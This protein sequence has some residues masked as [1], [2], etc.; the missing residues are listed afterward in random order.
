VAHL[1]T[2][3]VVVALHRIGLGLLLVTV[4]SVVAALGF[5][6]D[7]DSLMTAVTVAGLTFALPG[8]A[9][10]GLA[11]WFDGQAAALEGHPRGRR[12]IPKDSPA[13]HPFRAPLTG[14]LLAIAATGGGW[15]V[16]A[17][18]DPLLPGSVPFITFFAAVAISGWFGG[19][20]PAVLSTMLSAVIA[21]YFYMEPAYAFLL[22]DPTQAMRLGTF[23][24]IGL[25]IGG[26]SAA[27]R[28]ALERVQEL[29]D[30]LNAQRGAGPAAAP[31]K[32]DVLPD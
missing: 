32:R 4:A 25:V 12:P 23:V 14:Y 6:N 29:N 22:M 17:G 11:Y 26:L 18:I 2:D 30:Q 24:L 5:T 21:R 8:L 28:A 15:L 20:G 31:S 10:F 27:L 3:K 13:R 7:V 9:A 16:R 1:V 19:Y